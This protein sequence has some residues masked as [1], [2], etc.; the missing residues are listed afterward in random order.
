MNINEIL[1]DNLFEDEEIKIISEVLKTNSTITELNLSSDKRKK[2]E[3]I[4]TKR[5]RR[6]K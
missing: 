2:K 6:M 3:K 5:N 1:I 4:N